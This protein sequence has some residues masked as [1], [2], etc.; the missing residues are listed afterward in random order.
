VGL[1]ISNFGGSTLRSLGENNPGYQLLDYIKK[2]PQP[3]PYIFY[4][5]SASGSTADEMRKHGAFGATND[6][7]TLFSL[8]AQSINDQ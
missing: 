8:V 4:A 3:I 6:P 7:S 2:L 1:V 5:S